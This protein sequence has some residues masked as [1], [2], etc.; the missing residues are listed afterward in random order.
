[1]NLPEV[2]KPGF[3]RA[4]L[5]V[6]VAVLI[7]GVAL[8]LN[9]QPQALTALDWRKLLPVVVV[10]IP[11]TISLSTVEFILTGRLIGQ[12][13]SFLRALEVM[14]IGAAAN[15]MPV[16]GSAMVRLASLKAGGATYRDATAAVLFV[17]VVWLGIALFYA[18]ASISVATGGPVGPV[19]LLA[20]LVTLLVSALAA[21][22]ASLGPA[23][24][25]SIM[26]V[27]LLMVITDAARLLLC[28]G[29]IGATTTFAQAS[30]LSLSS[31]V[32]SAVS[33]VPAGLGIRE[34]VAAALSPTVGLA[35]ASGFLA[36][37]V[38]TVLGLMTITPLA[39]LLALRNRQREGSI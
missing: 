29:A 37:T 8:S 16:P 30:A 13:I 9:Q 28:L 32:G 4:V 6:A 38:N 14:V 15:I 19:F 1:M 33:I 10:G 23:F 39:M 27:K 31:V 11:V 21:M 17:A 3:K 24:T 20:G 18:G 2:R 22:R 12:R 26:V 5:V 35:I 25:L 34:V 36:A 7:V